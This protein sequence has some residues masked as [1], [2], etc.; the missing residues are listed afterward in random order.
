MRLHRRF[1]HVQDAENVG[2]GL[3][4]E[5]ATAHHD[6]LA[7]ELLD[8]NLLL[9]DLGRRIAGLPDIHTAD[10]N[11]L[12]EVVDKL[13]TD[14]KLTDIELYRIVLTHAQ[15]TSTYLLRYE[16]HPHNPNKKADEA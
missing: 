14:R 3:I 9:V 5:W 15:R 6:D 1:V 16:R 8:T 11:G 10:T 12:H 13:K 7:D 2:L 4:R